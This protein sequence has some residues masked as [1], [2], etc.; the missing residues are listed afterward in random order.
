[1][2]QCA[3]NRRRALVL[4]P[5]LSLDGPSRPRAV[6]AAL[7]ELMPVDVVT[8]DFDHGRKARREPLQNKIFA[9]IVYLKAPSYSTNVGVAR[10]ISHIVFSVRASVYFLR[11][12]DK[13]DTLYATAPLNLLAWIAFSRAGHAKKI[14]DVVD[15]W[16]DALPFPRLT[17]RAFQP[18]FA[19]W[20][21]LF[22]SSAR[23]ADIVISGSHVFLE[24]A[25]RYAR[26]EAHTAHI[27]LSHDSLESRV[28]KQSVFTLAYVGNL[29]RLYDFETLL[30]VLS[31]GDMREK[32]QL[33]IVGAGDRRQWLLHELTHREIRHRFYGV[34][35]DAGRLSSI[36]CGCHAGF[37]GY[38]RTTASFSYKAATYLAA[39]LPL[40]NSMHGDLH[41]LVAA[42]DLGV[43]YQAGD[44]RQLREAL[45]RL[46]RRTP[47]E[48]EAN[49]KNFFAEHL[50]TGKVHEEMRRYLARSLGFSS[51]RICDCAEDFARV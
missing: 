38:A 42:Y 8:A 14:L 26:K 22:S 25:K 3:T 30:D 47:G 24:E 46:L 49:C 17:R 13:Y 7:A 48:V 9:Q 50:E 41:G 10:L 39:G 51:A 37:N 35:H 43:N 15:V 6:A 18:V 27:Y 21:W 45:F 2:T 23:K 34:V 11:N 28:P 44:R 4:A 29:G 20:K 40:I 36:L 33:F 12:R 19:A 1:M 5:F 31:E 16:P 32:M